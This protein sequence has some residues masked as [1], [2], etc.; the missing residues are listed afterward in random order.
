VATG[1]VGSLRAL[2]YMYLPVSIQA[3]YYE[4]RNSSS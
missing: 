2:E 4:Y 3:W 1:R